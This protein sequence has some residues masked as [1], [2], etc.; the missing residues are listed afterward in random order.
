MLGTGVLTERSAQLIFMPMWY[1]GPQK[2]G[3]TQNSK[4]RFRLS[5]KRAEVVVIIPETEPLAV[6]RDRVSRDAPG[7]PRDASRVTEI[8]EKATEARRAAAASA[9]VGNGVIDLSIGGAVSGKST[10]SSSQKL[11]VSRAIRLFNVTQSMTEDGHYRWIIE[12]DARNPLKGRP[13]DCAEPR[14]TLLDKRRVPVH[15]IEPSVRIEIRCRREDLLIDDLELVDEGLWQSLKGR[16]GFDNRIAAA[17]Y[18]IRDQLSQLGLE[19][20]NI[21]DKFGRVTIANIIAAAV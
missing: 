3:A 12:S 4:V 9:K 14:L 11:E 7:D 6:D 18:Y 20:K 21:E 17:E 10:V 19:V 8:F 13:W 1:L 16:A 2:S 5:I 15:G